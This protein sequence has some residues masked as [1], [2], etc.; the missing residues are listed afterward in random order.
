MTGIMS[1]WYRN[2]WQAGLDIER[3]FWEKWVDSEGM[4]WKDDFLKRLDPLFSSDPLISDLFAEDVSMPVVLDAGSGP[5][6]AFP[7]YLYDG[8]QVILHAIDILADEYNAALRKAAVVPLV[9]VKK[10]EVEKLHT[11]FER[12]SFNMV[13]VRNTLD[14]LEDPCAAIE[15]MLSVVKPDGCIFLA[16]RRNLGSREDYQGSAIWNID[17]ENNQWIVWSRDRRY[18]FSRALEGYAKIEI[19]ESDLWIDLVVRKMNDRNE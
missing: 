2:R 14:H 10:L 19:I 17:I 16:H 7:K 4:E 5:L 3:R 13:F 11:G 6:S 18:N 1:R 8:R 15:S 9:E 12:D